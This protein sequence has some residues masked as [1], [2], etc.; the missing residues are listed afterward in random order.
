M[1]LT[2]FSEPPEFVPHPLLRGRHQQT[3]WPYFLPLRGNDCYR[4]TQHAVEVGDAESDTDEVILHDDCPVD[5][6]SGDRVVVL[7]HGLGGSHASGYMVRIASRFFERGYRVFRMDMRGCGAGLH[8][9]AGVFHADRNEDLRRAL[10]HVAGLCGQSRITVC[11][12]SLGANLTLKMLASARDRLPTQLDSAL[13]VEPPVD[14]GFC[15]RELSR[16]FGR[17]YDAWFAR[18]LWRDFSLRRQGLRR[19]ELVEITKAPTRLFDF[20]RQVTVR[21]GGY[22]S[23]D[24]YY[25]TASA[26]KELGKIQV[27]TV[28]LLAA[29]DPIVPACVVDA[30]QL[31]STTKLV[32]ANGGGHLGF[33]A[34]KG[35]TEDLDQRWM[36][37]RLIE[38]TAEVDRMAKKV[39]AERSVRKLKLKLQP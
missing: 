13:V 37:W 17:A 21:L 5:W 2:M 27:P 3:A 11:G 8:R 33:F 34:A 36:D 20:D 26:G 16:G 31:S 6:R 39:C 4:A 18:L 30:S 14:L 23:V 12:F 28:I 35:A 19:A 22:E 15:C 7:V 29:D 9:A 24:H 32:V 25:D 38:W 1:I 10:H